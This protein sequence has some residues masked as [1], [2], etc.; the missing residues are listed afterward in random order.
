MPYLVHCV[1]MGN[2]LPG[3][4]G[5]YEQCPTWFTVWAWTMTYL[6]HCVGMG[7]AY[8]WS[9]VR[10]WATSFHNLV[11]CLAMVSVI[12][13]YRMGMGNVLPGPLCGYE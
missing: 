13:V 8:T 2:V 3:S 7:N 6:V 4:H 5:G 12:L 1:G 11:N 10:V 9:T